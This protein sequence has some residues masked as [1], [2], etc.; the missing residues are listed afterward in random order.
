MTFRDRT[1]GTNIENMDQNMTVFKDQQDLAD[2]VSDWLIDQIAKS[3]GSRFDLAISGGSTPNLLFEVLA[4]KYP[5]SSLWQK[6]HFWW[7]DERMVAPNDPESNFGTAKKLLF[8][9]IA[10]PEKNIHRIKGESDPLQEAENYSQKIIEALTMVNGWPAFDLILLGMGDD[11]H[12]ASIFPNQTALLVSDHICE[13]AYHPVTSQVRITLTG[14]VINHAAII[15]FVITGASKAE[16]LSAIFFKDN[17]SK[18]LPAALIKPVNG[19]LVWYLD[20]E[21]AGFLS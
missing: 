2:H 15:C 21:A 20:E 16:R 17:K 11:G 14:R 4:N 1:E 5:D 3:K 18:Q 7:V 9:K 10:L 13:L 8:S 6:T 19:E 12:T